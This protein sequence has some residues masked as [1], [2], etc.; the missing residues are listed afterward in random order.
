MSHSKLKENVLFKLFLVV[1]SLLLSW[2]QMS[3]S[4]NTISHAIPLGDFAL[5]YMCHKVT[6]LIFYLFFDRYLHSNNLRELPDGKITLFI[7]DTI[8]SC[9]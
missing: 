7:V 6:F 3:F 1:I 2:L 9:K 5:L 4:H 8:F